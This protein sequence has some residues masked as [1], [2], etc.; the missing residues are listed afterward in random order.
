MAEKLPKD[1]YKSLIKTVKH[2]HKLDQGI[3]PAVAQEIDRGHTLTSDWVPAL[4]AKIGDSG[5]EQ[6]RASS[7]WPALVS[8]IDHALQRGWPRDADGR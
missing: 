4:A 3:A 7:W 5:V 1:I 2:G 6:M 8:S